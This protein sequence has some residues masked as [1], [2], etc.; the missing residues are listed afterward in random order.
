[1]ST[2]A[3]KRMFVLKCINDPRNPLLAAKHADVV[4]TFMMVWSKAK[5]DLLMLPKPYK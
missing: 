5:H 3:T 4:T 2:L 1:M